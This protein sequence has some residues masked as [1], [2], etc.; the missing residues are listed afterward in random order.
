MTFVAGLRLN[1]IAP[2]LLDCPMNS[3]IFTA[4][5]GQALA[6]ELRPG[7][8]LVMDN[9]RSHKG[10][11]ARLPT[12]MALA[13]ARNGGRVKYRSAGAENRAWHCARLRG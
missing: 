11:Q 3:A 12:G 7:D 10:Q 5:A 8:I 1:G 9:L 6:R 2:M 4:N 13:G